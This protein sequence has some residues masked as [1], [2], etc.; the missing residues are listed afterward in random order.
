MFEDSRPA[1]LQ[2]DAGIDPWAPFRMDHPGEI[3]TLLKQLLDTSV[4]LSL[5]GPD[6][7]SLSAQLWSVDD[8]AHRIAF[9]ADAG[10]PQL[11]RLMEGDEACAVA[12]VDAVKLQFDLH[13]LM[14]VHGARASALQ[15]ALPQVVY[16]F[17]RRSGYRVR[18]LERDSP[19]AELRHPA[20]PDMRLSL[21]V[22]DVSI[23]GCALFLPHDVPPLQPGTALQGV[24]IELDAD[25]R[26]LATVQLRH[27]SSI[28]PNA[29]GM[30]LGCELADLSAAAQ[31]AL[32]LYIDQTQKRRRMLTLD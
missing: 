12:Y 16:R 17:Q 21:R 24:R 13:N 4:P 30:R 28:Q 25:T 7:S 19:R 3:K 1:A 8:S 14:L 9:S 27:I 6:G 5:S 20:L 18:T 10:N 22:M 26:I 11:Q 15:A 23:G 32:Q 29:R 2:D 31:R